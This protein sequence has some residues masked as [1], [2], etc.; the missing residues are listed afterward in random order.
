IYRLDK[1]YVYHDG[2]VLLDGRKHATELEILHAAVGEL[3]DD[4]GRAQIAQHRIER[5]EIADGGERAAVEV[6][7]AHVHGDLRAHALDDPIHALVEARCGARVHSAVRLV[8]LDAVG[9]RL[10]Q[11]P[12]LGVHDPHEV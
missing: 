2:A 7:E 4:L 11:R 5:A 3:E 8:D 9:A 1:H 6:A 12:A 10:H